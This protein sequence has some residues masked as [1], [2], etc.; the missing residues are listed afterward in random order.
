MN[1]ARSS[2]LDTAASCVTTSL[3]S[4]PFSI[5][6]MTPASWPWATTQSVQ[7]E[8]NALFVAGHGGP[9][10]SVR[11]AVK[12]TPGGMS[13][14]DSVFDPAAVSGQRVDGR[15]QLD[16]CVGC[17]GLEAGFAET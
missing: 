15:A 2:A 16:G 5:I 8:R 4:R 11:A 1:P 9:F 17:H 7:Y 6:E 14:L 10:S 12:G 3:Q 13:L